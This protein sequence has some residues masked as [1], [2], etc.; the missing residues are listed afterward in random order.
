MS[1]LTQFI[2]L[3]QDETEFWFSFSAYTCGGAYRL[4][5]YRRIDQVPPTPSSS[6]SAAPPGP[7][8]GTWSLRQGGDTGVSAMQLV[9]IDENH[10]VIIDKVEANPLTINGH[11]VNEKSQSA[12]EFRQADVELAQ[13]RLGLPSTILARTRSNLSI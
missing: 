1:S 3:V 7:T 5:L 12:Q 13:W 9:V 6:S 4:N 8:S 10:A 11:P 2:G